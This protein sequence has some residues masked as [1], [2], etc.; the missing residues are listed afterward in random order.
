M[1]ESLTC[2]NIKFVVR[3]RSS[4]VSSANHNSLKLSNISSN[5][6]SLSTKSNNPEVASCT[7]MG[8]GEDLNSLTIINPE[9]HQLNTGKVHHHLNTGKVHAENSFL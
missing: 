7:I 3:I 6:L 1:D 9:H 5:K 8:E 4:E 2:E